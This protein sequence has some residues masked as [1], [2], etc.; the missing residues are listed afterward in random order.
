MKNDLYNVSSEN[1]V[2]DLPDIEGF[3]SQFEPQKNISLSMIKSL[4]SGQA[5]VDL[6]DGEYIHW[7]QLDDE[8]SEYLKALTEQHA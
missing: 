3:Y 2:W 5:I 6:S 4:I 8:A 7:L 1:D